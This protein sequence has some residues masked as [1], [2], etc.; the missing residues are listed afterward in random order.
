MG[1]LH[2][3]NCRGYIL[4]QFHTV[5]QCIVGS[6]G[7][8]ETRR[9]TSVMQSLCDL[10][11]FNVLWKHAEEDAA[12][13]TP[14]SLVCIAKGQQRLNHPSNGSRGR[15]EGGRWHIPEWKKSVPSDMFSGI[16]KKNRA[17][18]KQFM[19][20]CSWIDLGCQCDGWDHTLDR[21]PL[22]TMYR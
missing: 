16:L 1:H 2:P 3:S 22:L 19:V 14:L 4:R 21:W 7:S 6:S 10:T 17:W 18:W 20:G 15:W 9:S 12:G 8:T 11:Q 5:S 13:W